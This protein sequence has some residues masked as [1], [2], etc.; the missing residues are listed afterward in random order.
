MPE[1]ANVATYEIVIRAK[2]ISGEKD[3]KKYN[4]FSYEAFDTTGKKCKIKFTKEVT[5]QPKE[6][7]EFT[8][9]VP[10]SAM[11]RDKKVRWNEYWVR[12]IVDCKPYV[13]HFDEN[14]EDL[15]F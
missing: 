2:R 7:G 9:I 11:N 15:P 12:Q 3:G 14:V 6:D 10:K 4:F 13:P 1:Q 5:N 8:I